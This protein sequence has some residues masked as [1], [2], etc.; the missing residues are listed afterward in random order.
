MHFRGWL[1]VM[2]KL[3]LESTSELGGRRA[4]RLILS[5]RQISAWLWLRLALVDGP[6]PGLLRVALLVHVLWCGLG[7]GAGWQPPRYDFN[8]H[9]SA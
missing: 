9:I 8:W 1:S 6:D 5:C 4:C 2:V 7:V 3:L